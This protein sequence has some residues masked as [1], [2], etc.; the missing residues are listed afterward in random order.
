MLGLY[1]LKIM[2]VGLAR[3]IHFFYLNECVAFESLIFLALFIN[4]I[5][6]SLEPR[7]QLL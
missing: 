5:Y 6:S 2:E 7:H 4:V 1:I 3:G